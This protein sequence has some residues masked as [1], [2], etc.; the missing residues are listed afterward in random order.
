MND[1]EKRPIDR[2][3]DAAI[4][5]K[6]GVEDEGRVVSTYKIGEQRMLW[7]KERGIY[8]VKLPDEIDPDRAN[9]AL[10]P[11]QQ[12]VCE[13]GA[14]DDIVQRVLLTADV[15]FN[16]HAIKEEID[17][18]RARE[19]VFGML[20]ELV[21]MR[22][23]PNDL[24][25]VIGD[26]IAEYESRDDDGMSV[27]LP[28]ISDLRPCCEGFTQRGIR[29]LASLK[30]LARMFYPELGSRWITSLL[31]MLKERYGEDDAFY[32][33]MLAAADL[34]LFLLNMRNV[35]EHSG[36]GRRMVVTDFSMSPMGHIDPPTIEIEHPDTPQSRCDAVGLMKTLGESVVTIVECFMAR[37]C[38]ANVR[39]G[40][41][42]PIA[43]MNLPEEMHRN[44]VRYGY[45]TEIQGELVRFG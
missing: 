10:I 19:L 43:L 24:E 8:E 14:D 2:R 3:R 34:L 23:I 26:R 16:E 25:Q 33:F 5:L 31:R 45:F 42:P 21:E 15:L 1:P 41:G 30:E 35:V 39:T 27:Q 17:C 6:L 4:V 36:P 11:S 12:R 32:E 7:V 13:F 37:L 9:I 29:V 20:V 22:R 18:A 40:G 28:T 44:G 38:S